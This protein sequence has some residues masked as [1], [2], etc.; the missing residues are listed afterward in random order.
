MNA[1]PDEPSRL[2]GTLAPC[3]ES[4]VRQAGPTCWQVVQE[5][6][7]AM[8]VDDKGMGL[9]SD[10]SAALVRLLSPSKLVVAPYCLPGS[11]ILLYYSL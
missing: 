7:P 10:A 3:V 11:L 6:G 9:F 5:V 4:T 1:G 8:Q 2:L